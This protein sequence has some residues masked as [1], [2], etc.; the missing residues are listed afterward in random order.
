LPVDEAVYEVTPP[1]ESCGAAGLAATLT[2]GALIENLEK[3]YA[4]NYLNKRNFESDALKNLVLGDLAVGCGLDAKDVMFALEKDFSI[5]VLMNYMRRGLK[6]PS[7]S[8]K[9]GKKEKYV[10][11]DFVDRLITENI[12]RMFDG[13]K[14][15]FY[16]SEPVSVAD[17]KAAIFADTLKDADAKDIQKFS[18]RDLSEMEA[19][20]AVTA[21]YAGEL[22]NSEIFSKFITL[23]GHSKPLVDK[24]HELYNYCSATG[25]YA[26]ADD[27]EKEGAESMSG[28]FSALDRLEAAKIAVGDVWKVRAE[29][30][31]SRA[32]MLLDS[33][34][35]KQALCIGQQLKRENEKSIF[36]RELLLDIDRRIKSLEYEPAVELVDNICAVAVDA[37]IKD[38]LTRQKGFM[39][40]YRASD[41]INEKRYLEALAIYGKITDAEGKKA[42]AQTIGNELLAD[43]QHYAKGLA[44]GKP[45]K[46]SVP[47]MLEELKT[48][49][50][51]HKEILEGVQNAQ[52]T[53]N[54]YLTD[55]ALT[56]EDYTKAF[57][58]I[59]AMPECEKRKNVVN[60]C[61]DS[62]KK[63]SSGM[64]SETEDETLETQGYFAALIMEADRK[65][66]PKQ[67]T[68]EL[69]EGFNGARTAYASMLVNRGASYD[70]I[71]KI[72]K[73][74]P[75]TKKDDVDSALIERIN[76]DTTDFIKSGH[77]DSARTHFS[78]LNGLFR[79]TKIRHVVDAAARVVQ[80]REA[81]SHI[82]AGYYDN[83]MLTIAGL[84]EGEKK[85]ELVRL[86]GAVYDKHVDAAVAKGGFE[87]A[88][89]ETGKLEKISADSRLH[90]ILKTKKDVLL[91]AKISHFVK[92]RNYLE[93]SN[94][95]KNISDEK[96]R[97]NCYSE[98]LN[99]LHTEV[100]QYEEQ[101]KY[102]EAVALLDSVQSGD[103]R[104]QRDT[105]IIKS[106]VEVSHAKHCIEQ[107]DYN[108]AIEIY[109]KTM[110][111][112]SKSTVPEHFVKNLNEYVKK[113]VS[114][115]S[116]HIYPKALLWLGK[117]K[118]LT[119][120]TETKA[121]IDSS[122]LPIKRDWANDALSRY[123]FNDAYKIHEGMPK[124]E[125]K[126]TVKKAI[127]T[128]MTEYVEL[129]I[130]TKHYD[131]AMDEL[132]KIGERWHGISELDKNIETSQD[133]LRCYKAD[134]LIA[135]SKYEDALAVYDQIGPEGTELKKS[136]DSRFCSAANLEITSA[137]ESKD[138][139]GTI[140][141]LN[142]IRDRLVDNK[143]KEEFKNKIVLL[144]K[145]QVKYLLEKKK[146]D[147]AIEVQRQQRKESWADGYALE[148]IML[149]PM[150]GAAKEYI[151]ARNYSEAREMLHKCE[152]ISG[153]PYI[154]LL[155]GDV[156]RGVGKYDVA[157]QQYKEV[158][159]CTKGSSERDDYLTTMLALK[160]R[161]RTLTHMSGFPHVINKLKLYG[162]NRKLK[163]MEYAASRES[164]VVE[165]LAVKEP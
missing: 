101:K 9:V 138:Y 73:D 114:A 88:L 38:V 22:L 96:L 127:A 91:K 157:D 42:T 72:Y 45:A 81:K 97:A 58:I 25:T 106:V 123:E 46:D 134:D 112:Y 85:D 149:D 23:S 98:L 19:K 41:L 141:K 39:T 80:A 27:S 129:M 10:K 99:N 56:D 13:N 117:M 37:E 51:P 121:M 165:R 148:K 4:L 16:N 12:A 82:D 3:E 75:D 115:G 47:R 53:L 150:L 162:V 128:K 86:F 116:H 103:A 120:D 136:L 40:L 35:Y 105:T 17:I 62:I 26:A 43:I 126:S 154:R 113:A 84:P 146:Y 21:F 130:A 70:D 29:I 57:D 109:S 52:N 14:N 77:Y 32:K 140:E 145:E 31:S 104:L 133:R 15:A 30:Y 159:E 111:G 61:T 144:R 66:M 49:A 131:A 55:M 87:S 125:E 164:N 60:K 68:G 143:A 28:F 122:N 6:A 76:N 50:A 93:A 108:K 8:R 161:R 33:G 94:T 20:S 48:A 102:S 11:Q 36:K 18:T 1:P 124:C 54:E 79:N 71:S 24:I 118:E 74:L 63:Y 69:Y 132:A 100:K 147:D 135:E 78:K 5:A 110:E 160:R 163:K 65:S 151:N 64:P 158:Y 92:G 67:I 155:W 137:L 44:D 156:N 119:R 152:T 107:N 83:A 89:T 142:A 153:N 95:L 2:C 90:S 34:S 7:T 59:A 139:N